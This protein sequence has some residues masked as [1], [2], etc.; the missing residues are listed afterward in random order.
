MKWK[1]NNPSNYSATLPRV[2]QIVEFFFPFNGDARSRFHDWLYRNNIDVDEYMKEASEGW[3]YVHSKLEDYMAWIK[4]TWRKYKWFVE[5]GIQFLKDFN[6]VP[7]YMEHYVCNTHY[8]WTID[9]IWEINWQK[10]IID[11]KT[12]GL[13]KYKFNLPIPEY[14]KPYDKLKKARLQLSLYA[15]AMK[16]K[17]IGVVE[18]TPTGYYFHELVPYTSAELK[19]MIKEFKFHYVDQI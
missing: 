11:W 16:I 7:V 8:Q 18:L 9:L 6:V 2:S 3:T 4:Y 13:S 15:L 14:K 1:K 12:Y 17:K 19:T 5:W 10:W